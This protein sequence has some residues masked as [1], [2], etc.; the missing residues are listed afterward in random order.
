VK[1]WS[2]HRIAG[3]AGADLLRPHPDGRAGDG[4][5]RVV[6]DSREVGPGDLFVGIPGERF[7][8]HGS[9]ADLRKLLRI[10][11]PGLVAQVRETLA[12]LGVAPPESIPA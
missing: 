7:V 1:H 8:D 6:I 3:T 4:P 10:D 12:E 9:V 2:D 5:T 11:A